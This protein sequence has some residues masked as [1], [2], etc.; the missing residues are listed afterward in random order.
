MMSRKWVA[1]VCLGLFALSLSASASVT[2]PNIISGAVAVGGT[3]PE[4]LVV[5]KGGLWEGAMPFVDRTVVFGDA[6][7]LG[8]LDFVQTAVDDK[9]DADVVYQ[10]TVDK[11]GT[12]FLIIDNRVG[13]ENTANP[14]T[15]GGGIM[16]WVAAM[17]FTQTDRSVNISTPATVYALEVTAGTYDLGAQ[18]NG[19]SR[20]MYVVAAAPAG[21]NLQP[22]IA[23]LPVNP[24]VEPGS[25]LTLDATITD[26]GIPGTGI[27]VQW[28]TVSTP[29]GATVNYSPNTT[30]E[31]VEISFSAVGNYTLKVSASDGEKT[32]AKMINVAVQIPKFA[33]ACTNW[34]EACND[35][36]K[37]PDTH[38]KPTTR[39]FVRNH[40]A[41][42]R[43]IQFIQYDISGVKEAGKAFVN[44]F[45]SINR[46]K[47]SL[48][49][50]LSV[51]AVKEE[52]DNVDLDAGTWNNMPGV[53]NTPA[54]SSADQITIATLDT[55]DLS[56][57]LLEQTNIPAGTNSNTWSN[58]ST[59]VALDEFLNA[60]DDG[61]IL[62][63]FVTFSPQDADFEIVCQ[64]KGT[65]EAETGLTG[66]ILRG[67]VVTPTWATSPVPQMNTSQSTALAQLSWTS[68][69]P[70]E[71]GATVTCD[72]F[73]GSTEPNV[74]RPDYGLTT[75]ATGLSG[76]SVAIPAGTLAVNT[77]Y[78]WV[79]DIHDSIAGTTRGY[80]WNFNTNNVMPTVTMEAPFQY[81]WLNNAGD[82]ASA[83]AVINAAVEDDNFPSPYTLLWEQVSAPDGVT[84]TIDPSN[85]EDITLVLPQAGT[86]TFKLSANDG[87]LTGSAT[88]EIF[89]GATPCDAAKAKPGYEQMPADFDNN[90]Y[91]NMADLSE[92]ASQWLQCHSFMD[93]PCI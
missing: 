25:T 65:A 49:E 26:D 55:A 73:F 81:L 52:L 59:S 86:Y 15:L 14:P 39:M 43:R 38:Y 75:L 69:A 78:Y 40:A 45:L 70:S 37:G 28:S 87:D 76:N 72:V 47:G 3:A 10:V 57:L 41:P 67:N 12:L 88:T 24:Q 13:D 91:V 77:V 20:V 58:T 23:G 27:S 33:V 31:D 35:P 64:G 2:D 4:P 17:G 48:N 60:D 53:Q 21:F 82:P 54:P 34:L 56:D 93:A 50:V 6:N 9:A 22:S 62:L 29:E 74:L 80:V 36:D 92:F 84:V 18:N 68:P 32:A 5:V 71:A 42:R 16:D 44:S 90:C 11:P 63:M 89:V 19:N 85:V 8:G 7:D 30:S 83:T 61:I 66:I 1:V 46:Y 51:Y 79:V